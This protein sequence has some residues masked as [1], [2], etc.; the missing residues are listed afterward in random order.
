MQHTEAHEGKR[1]NPKRFKRAR[2][3]DHEGQGDPKARVVTAK[4]NEPKFLPVLLP[5]AILRRESVDRENIQRKTDDRL[6][7]T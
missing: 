1:L 2:Q 4:T 6:R 5:R 7:R 3:R